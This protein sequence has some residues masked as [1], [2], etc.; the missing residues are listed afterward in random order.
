MNPTYAATQFYRHLLAMPGWQQMSM[1]DAAQ[2]V[3]RSGFPHAYA[4][5]EQ[6]ARAIVAAV[7][8]ATCTPSPTPVT[9]PVPANVR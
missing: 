2:A 6:A 3:Q 8:G 9:S 7:S 5:H 1:N 4:P